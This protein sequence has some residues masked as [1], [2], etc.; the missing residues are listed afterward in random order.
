MEMIIRKT[1]MGREI[2]REKQKERQK[3][4]VERYIDR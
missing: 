4:E 2:K 1:K 3:Y